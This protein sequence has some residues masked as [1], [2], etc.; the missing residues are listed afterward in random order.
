MVV[1]KNSIIIMCF[2][3]ESSIISYLIGLVPSYLLLKSNNKYNKHI[4]L[5]CLTFIQMQFAEFLMWSDIKCQNNLNQYGSILAHL[6]LCLQPLSI[7]I[8]A[9]YFKTTTI[10]Q[11]L[12]LTLIFIYMIPFLMALYH[13]FVKK[14]VKLCS[15][16][17]E[18]GQLIWDFNMSEK[19]GIYSLY[20]LFYFPGLFIVWLYLKDNKKGNVM[21]G[22]LLS[23]I[24]LSIINTKSFNE[25]TIFK[26]WESKWCFYAV[27]FPT[28]INIL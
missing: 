26:D 21:F 14:K 24:I 25:K 13:H 20:S 19:S 15:T 11:K 12:L 4:G 9:Y 27:I 5:F 7:L 6:I 8:G 28:I 23:S 17:N 1:I 2:S 22:L 3:K 10:D 16:T 18:R